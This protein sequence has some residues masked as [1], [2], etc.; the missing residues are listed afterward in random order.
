MLP[1]EALSRPAGRFGDVAQTPLLMLNAQLSVW[2]AGWLT[3]Q[4]SD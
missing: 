2:L 4:I 3:L 1:G